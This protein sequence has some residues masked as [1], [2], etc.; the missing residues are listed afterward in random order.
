MSLEE[1]CELFSI[2]DIND[3]DKKL[4]KKTYHKLCL[5]YHPDKNDHG[6]E[7]FIKVKMCYEKLN[8]I[9][10]ER[11][12]HDFCDET[13]YDDM[14]MNG[15]NTIKYVVNYLE[16]FH[17]LLNKYPE[18]VYLDVKIEQVINRCLY[19]TSDGYHIPLWYKLFP[20]YSEYEKKYFIF[21]IRIVDLPSNVHIS[22]NNDIFIEIPYHSFQFGTVK[23][24]KLCNGFQYNFLVTEKCIKD[25]HIT[26]YGKGI[27]RIKN[28]NVYDTSELSNV[29]IYWK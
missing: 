24:V 26:I 20:Q 8:K 22:R 27:P 29:K 10:E 18:I 28:E 16:H 15:I 2:S 25:R 21:I 9:L 1:C 7:E 5:K 3:I 23:E 17:H 19:T 4:L 11:Q 14:L 6:E 13:T 12:N